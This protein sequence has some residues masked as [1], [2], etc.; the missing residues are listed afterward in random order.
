MEAPLGKFVNLITQAP[1]FNVD[2]LKV[3][4]CLDLRWL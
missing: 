2:W 3:E 1:S 4:D